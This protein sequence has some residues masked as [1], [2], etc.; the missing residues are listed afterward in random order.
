MQYLLLYY[1]I[2][3]YLI[4]FFW[5]LQKKFHQLSKE[6]HPKN[7]YTVKTNWW[8]KKKEV[9]CFLTWALD[10]NFSRLLNFHKILLFLGIWFRGAIESH[11]P[12][13]STRL[14]F[15]GIRQAKLQTLFKGWVQKNQPINQYWNFYSLI[16]VSVSHWWDTVY[17]AVSRDKSP[18]SHLTM[19]AMLL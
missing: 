12:L 15:N 6:N 9:W 1:L 14:C 18:F 16:S 19:L 5:L 10:C 2:L 8:F 13:S 11:G 17:Q 3:S 7:M 4:Q